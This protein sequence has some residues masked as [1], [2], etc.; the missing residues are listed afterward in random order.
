MKN[1]IIIYIFLVSFLA[2]GFQIN[3]S[4]DENAPG[5]MRL[6][7]SEAFVLIDGDTGQ[8]LFERNMH[9]RMYPASI[10]KVMTALL[11]LESGLPPENSIV[12]MS[13]DAVWS[14]GRD[15]SHIALDVDERLTLEEALYAIAIESG[16]D[17]SN[18]IAE[19]VSGSMDD[20]AE[21]M[22]QRAKELGARNTNF[23]NAHGLPEA[24]MHYTTAYDMALVM[25]AAIKIPEFNQIFSAVTFGMFP[26]NIQIARGQE[27]RTFNRRNSLI[28]GFYAYDGILSEKTG[29]TGDAGRTYT[30][31][32]RRG[33]RTLVLVLMKS[34]EA[35]DRWEDATRLF[36]HGFNEFVQVSYTAG[37]IAGE[38]HAAEFAEGIVADMRLIPEEGFSCLILKS[39]AKEDI[40]ISYE[41]YTDMTGGKINGRAVFSADPQMSNLMFTELGQVSLQVYLDG[42]E[43]KA[44]P[45][46]NGETAPGESAPDM[47]DGES[48]VVSVLSGIYRIASVILQIIGIAAVIAIILYIR[49]YTA[50][51]KRKRQRRYNRNRN[52]NIYG[53]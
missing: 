37:E 29:W 1:K 18:G 52:N 10:T 7:Q 46:D 41:F 21:K 9:T 40:N 2:A 48:A 39:L 26:T 31:A 19:L 14:V 42:Y 51:Q 49:H 44:D 15:T 38:N 20:F 53:R 25:A 28:E 34:P 12:T 36:D 11:A 24:G 32:A 47:T 50:M 30:A 4:A 35:A 22:T 6:M 23:T 45:A 5:I 43:K 27:A 13:Y 8:V 3:A 33:D 16:N 17:A